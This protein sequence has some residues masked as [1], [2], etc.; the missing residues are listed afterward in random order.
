[1]GQEKMK[2]KVGASVR[3][4]RDEII[5]DSGGIRKREVKAGE[6]QYWSRGGEKI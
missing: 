2:G 5:S 3:T 6:N 1:M 4:E